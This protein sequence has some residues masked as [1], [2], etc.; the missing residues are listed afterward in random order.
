MSDDSVFLGVHEIGLA[1]KDLD[2]AIAK[3]ET[4]FG[5]KACPVIEAPD[6]G[7]QMKFAYVHV[8]EQRINLMQDIAPDSNGPIGRAVARRGEGYFNSII[9]V[10]DLDATIERLRAAGVGLVE[11]E[12]R[13]FKD[14][15]YDGR[16]YTL[17][18]VVWT[19]PRTF[20]GMLVEFQE[21][22]WAT[23]EQ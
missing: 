10:T 7:I 11:D 8:G 2:A 5:T 3:F 13:V 1:V 23:D 9:Q 14:G 15:E 4:V 16:R 12:P 6:D 17:N 22:V 18:R 21:F 19:D 20:H